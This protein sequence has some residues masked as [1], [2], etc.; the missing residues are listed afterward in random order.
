MVMI[1]TEGIKQ[2]KKVNPTAKNNQALR[3]NLGA[4]LP[5]T[6]EQIGGRPIIYNQVSYTQ[7]TLDVHQCQYV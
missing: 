7:L 3:D 2:L 1:Q 5:I 4:V 6:S